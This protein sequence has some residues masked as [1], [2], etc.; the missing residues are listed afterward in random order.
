MVSLW[1]IIQKEKKN[2]VLSY[3]RIVLIDLKAFLFPFF[4]LSNK[5]HNICDFN[6]S[7]LKYIDSYSRVYWWP[8]RE[9]S[10]LI[11]FIFK[12][13]IDFFLLLRLFCYLFNIKQNRFFVFFESSD[14][15]IKTK[16]IQFHSFHSLF[17]CY[18]YEK[19]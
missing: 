14:V 4:I 15:N 11:S 3:G 8:S 16:F 2:V 10:L 17:H 1:N 7:N 19:K 18:I 5:K 12:S 13:D 9:I 6:K